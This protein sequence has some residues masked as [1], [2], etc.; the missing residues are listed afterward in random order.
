MWTTIATTFSQSIPQVHIPI[1]EI[2]LIHYL[3]N[4][5][6]YQHQLTSLLTLIQNLALQDLHFYT[7]AS[8]QNLQSSNIKSGI[9]WICEN[10]MS[11]KFNAA[12]TP[13]PDLIRTELE[14]IIS[15]LLTI[16]NNTHINIH[17]DNNTAI[18]NLKQTHFSKTIQ[19]KIGILYLSLIKLN[20]LKTFRLPYTKSNHTLI[21]FITKQTYLQNMELTNQYL[22]L[23][24]IF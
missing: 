4:H 14:A 9:G 11:I 8:I 7:D 1:Q 2:Q 18:K 13:Y 19:N 24:I 5:T 23:S 16:P 15:L 6:I 10:N 20:L 21:P 22:K 3:T 17:L 12:T